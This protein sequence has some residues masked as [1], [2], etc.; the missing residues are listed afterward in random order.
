MAEAIPMGT[1][2][3]QNRGATGTQVDLCRLRNDE[4]DALEAMAAKVGEKPNNSP[5]KQVF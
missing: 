4:L 3:R 1:P 5:E 2:C